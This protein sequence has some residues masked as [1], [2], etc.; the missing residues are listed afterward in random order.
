MDLKHFTMENMTLHIC[1]YIDYITAFFDN[2]KR[3]N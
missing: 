2:I 3:K 1:I